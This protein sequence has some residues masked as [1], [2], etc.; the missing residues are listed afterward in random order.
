MAGTLVLVISLAAVGGALVWLR[1]R[2]NSV[3]ASNQYAETQTFYGVRYVQT[4]W[5]DHITWL[6]G[7]GLS[8]NEV[9]VSY[10][11]G[12]SVSQDHEARTVLIEWTGAQSALVEY[13]SAVMPPAGAR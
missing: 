7:N 2:L 6:P 12:V 10:N 5:A 13:G 9:R 8:A 4:L 3:S 11:H 1:K